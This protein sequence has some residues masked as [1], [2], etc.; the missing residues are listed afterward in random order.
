MA[1]LL[2]GA[3]EPGAGAVLARGKVLSLAGAL[4]PLFPGS[5]LRKG[6]TVVVR[7]GQGAV[8]GTTTLALVLLGNLCRDDLRCAVVGVPELCLVAASQMGTELERLVLVPAAGPKWPLVVAALLEG[9]DVVLLKLPGYARPAD[10]RRLEA[11]AREKGPVL[12]VMG[13]GW[14]RADVYLEVVAARWQGLQRGYGHLERCEIE[15]V[16]SGRAVGPRERRAKL[17]LSVP[18]LPGA[19]A[20]GA[21]AGV[22]AGVALGATVPGAA[23]QAVLAV[24]GARETRPSC[25]GLLGAEAEASASVVG[26]AD[27]LA[28]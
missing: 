16:A 14:P 20:P 23:V 7:R 3:V 2:E 12:V 1:Q 21:A 6:S 18:S 11:R 13:P 9:L 25:A 26:A 8:N 10:A 24:G 19:A 4:A 5:A 17:H 27:S 28:G 15:V 22:A